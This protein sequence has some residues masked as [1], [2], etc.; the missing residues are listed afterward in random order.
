[1]IIYFVVHDLLFMFLQ[2]IPFSR[3]GSKIDIELLSPEIHRSIFFVWGYK[4]ERIRERER[5]RER[6]K[7]RE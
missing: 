1:M 3:F 6:E 4:R 2:P 7:E 5:E